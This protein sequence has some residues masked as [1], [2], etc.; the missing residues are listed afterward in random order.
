MSSVSKTCVDFVKGF[1]G[2]FLEAYYCPAGVLTIGYGH[3]GDDVKPGMEISEAEA[4]ALLAADLEH[5]ARGVDQL[6]DAP[7]ND[8][9]FSALVSFCFNLGLGAFKGSTLFKKLKAHDYKGAAD[10]FPRWNKAGGRV[11]AGLTRRREAERAL[12]LKPV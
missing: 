9:Q 5:F 12:F 10:E 2:K 3:T 4:D 11:L 6:V 7:L 1:E 8:N